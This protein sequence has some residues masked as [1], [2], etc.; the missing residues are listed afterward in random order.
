MD[1][2]A[3]SDDGSTDESDVE[4]VEEE[5]TLISNNIELMDCMHGRRSYQY[6]FDW[7]PFIMWITNHY[8]SY[9]VL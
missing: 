7:Q 2:E 9:Y 8:K 3:N 6:K 4:K 5:I 1:T